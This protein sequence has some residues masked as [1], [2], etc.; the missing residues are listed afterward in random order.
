MNLNNLISYSVVEDIVATYHGSA[1]IKNLETG[2]YVHS[3]GINLQT[4]GL[5][6]PDQIIGFNIW[7]LDSFMKIYWGRTFA[8]DIEKLDLLVKNE[9]CKIK[10]IERVFLNTHGFVCV[11]S[12]SKIPILNNNKCVIDI[13]TLAQNITTSVKLPKLYLLYKNLYSNSPFTNKEINLKFLKYLKIDTMFEDIPTDAEI[14][15]LLARRIYSTHKELAFYLKLASK[16]VELHLY[17]LR[18]KIKHGNLTI[19]LSL[20]QDKDIE[21]GCK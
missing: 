5:N 12:L 4:F 13:L 9:K 15:I 1:H 6:A 20:L 14:K 11:N 21:H 17:N 2:K 10:N 7:D 19:V 3:N 8:A 16:T 18:N